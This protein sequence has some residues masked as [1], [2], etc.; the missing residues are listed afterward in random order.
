MMRLPPKG[1]I[2][3]SEK[4]DSKDDKSNGQYKSSADKIKAVYPELESWSDWACV[5]SFISY[6]E[7]VYYCGNPYD[8]QARNPEFIAYLYAE[9]ELGSRSHYDVDGLDGLEDEWTI[10][11]KKKLTVE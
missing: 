7:K 4:Y 2:F 10:Y 11:D 1:Y 9:Q 5:E 8:G 6:G 3:K